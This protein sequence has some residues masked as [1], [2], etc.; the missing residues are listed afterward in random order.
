MSQ[1]EGKVAVVTGGSL[2]IG[3]AAAQRLTS[4]GAYVFI[5]GR[6]QAELDEA[7][8]R[9][10]RNVS[11]VRSD[12]SN[13]ED[14]DRLYDEVRKVKG[15]IDILFVNPAVL[16][17]GAVDAVTVK[18]F[19]EQFDANVKGALFTVQ[20]SLPPLPRRRVDHPH[21]VDRGEGLGRPGRVR[22]D[23]GGARVARAVVGA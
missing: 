6:R 21:G 1:H 14:L 4:E 2:G 18:D 11:G 19:D 20:K 12:S 15:H 8:R 10:G 23:Q 17:A 16:R 22:G 9:I 5:T 7:V 13:L 3:L